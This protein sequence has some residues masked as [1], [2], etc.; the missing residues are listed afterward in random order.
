ML[1]LPLH[2]QVNKK[3]DNDDDDL[4][5]YTMGHPDLIAS[6]F[7][8]YVIGIQR[9]SGVES[10]NYCFISAFLGVLGDGVC[11]GRLTLQW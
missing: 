4:S 9:V 2:L 3:S 6:N 8:E 5:I 10:F 7:M 1:M 11:R